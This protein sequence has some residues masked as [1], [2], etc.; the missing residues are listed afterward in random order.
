MPFVQ[1]N[2]IGPLSPEQKARVSADITR[3]FVEHCG[4]LPESVNI[5]FIELTRDDW[6]QAGRL[7]SAP[8]GDASADAPR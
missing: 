1:V 3:S 4:K 2:A 8:S 6:A 5:A 7:K